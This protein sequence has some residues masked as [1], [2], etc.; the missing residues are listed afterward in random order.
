[1]VTKV[2]PGDM[3]KIGDAW[4]EDDKKYDKTPEIIHKQRRE[5]IR[6][7]LKRRKGWS[8]APEEK[9][10]VKDEKRRRKMKNYIAIGSRVMAKWG[11]EWYSGTIVDIIE[12]NNKIVKYDVQFDDD[13]K[14]WKVPANSKHIKKEKTKLYED[15]GL[16]F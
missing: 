13:G 8:T 6:A 16:K 5:Q 15:G 12:K 10:R 4:T 1:M 7:D 14:L 2:N 9:K 11:N 3:E